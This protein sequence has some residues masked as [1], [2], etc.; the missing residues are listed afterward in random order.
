[1]IGNGKWVLEWAVQLVGAQ[2]CSCVFQNVTE[3]IAVVHCRGHPAHANPTFQCCAVVESMSWSIWTNTRVTMQMIATLRSLLPALQR[4][5]APTAVDS[6][7][8]L[9]ED[10]KE[11][12]RQLP[13]QA[14]ADA[15]SDP[16]LLKAQH[17]APQCIIWVKMLVA[18]Q[19]TA[20]LD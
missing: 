18:Q 17:I 8:A 9:I 1:M 20:K 19:G 16:Q 3:Y 12:A 11:A 2:A 13:Q 14:T 10:G 4:M 6:K 7:P 5:A 15:T